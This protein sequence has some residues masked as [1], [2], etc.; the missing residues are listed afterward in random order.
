MVSIIE[1]FG[2]RRMRSACPTHLTGRRVRSHTKVTRAN[3][4]KKRPWYWD[5]VHQKHSM[6]L[7]LQLPRILSR[8]FNGVWEIYTDASSKQLG[9][10]ITQGKWPLAFFSRKLLTTQQKYKRDRTRT[11]GHS[12]K[13]SK[14]SKACCGDKD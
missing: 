10:V 12:G 4:A 5:T 3:K 11:T 9:S 7:R 6:A 13:H 2:Q 1:I 8:L 14:S